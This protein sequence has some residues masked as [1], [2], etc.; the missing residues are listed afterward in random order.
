MR[1]RTGSVSLLA[2]LLAGA[3]PLAAQSSQF[4]AR[5]LGVPVRSYSAHALGLGGGLAMFDSE[6]SLNPASIAGLR[7][8]QANGA[9]TSTWRQS[10]TPFGSGFARDT[11]YGLVQAAGP[12]HLNGLGEVKVTA[13]ASLSGYLDRTYG[14]ASRDSITIRDQRFLVHDSLT[15]QGGI[16]DLRIAA[17]WHPVPALI[18]GLGVHAL[19]GATRVYATRVVDAGPYDPVREVREVSYLGYGVSGGLILR[20]SDRVVLGG[21]ARL[22]ASSRIERDTT[23]VGSVAFPATLGVGGRV[24]PH[25]RLV[26]A[27]HLIHRGWS[28]ADADIRDQ[29]GLGARD[30]RELALGLEWGRNA[31]DPTRWPVRLGVHSMTLPFPLEDGGRGRETGVSAGSGLRLGPAGRGSLDVTLQ[32][33]WRAEGEGWRERAFLISVGLAIRP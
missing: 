11:R 32:H 30:S 4:S 19:P 22:D 28:R 23:R 15:S 13:S 1:A 29:G 12:V 16:A 6:S 10:D 9:S 5:G 14:L 21:L 17:S 26:V 8:L 7:L 25:A 24:N 27:G 33:I 3:A 2:A 20:L 18:V 31:S